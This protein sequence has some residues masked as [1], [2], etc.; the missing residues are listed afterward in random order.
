MDNPR[1]T[2]IKGLRIHGTTNLLFHLGSNTHPYE[3]LE[4]ILMIV[5]E[6]DADTQVTHTSAWEEDDDD[7]INTGPSPI[8]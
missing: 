5:A 7:D 6:S 4:N 1:P 3:K 2:S 8:I